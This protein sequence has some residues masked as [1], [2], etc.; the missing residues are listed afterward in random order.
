METREIDPVEDLLAYA[1]PARPLA[2]LRRGDGI[3][4]VGDDVVETIRVSAGSAPLRSDAI[5]DAW[6]TLAQ[7]A[8][9]DDALRLPGSGL[10]AFGALTFD[11]DSAADSVLIVPSL[12]I[13]RHRGRT[14]LT[15]IG[16]AADVHE[17][18]EPQADADTRP[19]GPHWAG[20][21]GPGAQSPQGYQDSVRQALD[22]ISA[23]ELSKVV[24]AR[25]LTGSVPAGS[26]L[27]RLVRALSTGYPDTWAF[28]V[29]GLIGASPETLVTVQQRTVTARVLA[30]TI[31]RGADADADTEASAHL[32]SSTKDLDEHE[33]AVQSVLASLRAHTRVLAASEQPFLLKL[34]NLFHLATDVEGELADGGSSLDL[35]GALHPTAAVAGTPTSA[36][37]AAIRE[38]EP[39]DRG[40]Y[41]GPVG[42]VDAAGNGE[43]AIALR[44]AQFSPEATRIAVTAYAGAGIVSGSDPE[45]ELLETRV[46]F[47]PLVDALA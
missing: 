42:W 30:G 6:R 11:E 1:D 40:R 35:I 44:C 43:W 16:R 23:G 3:V 37:I 45:S 41:A 8:D 14:W 4:A 7:D 2:W 36:A 29:D 22:R 32:A 5:A 24:L 33:Y 31:G 34:P 13:G 12:V 27:R 10:V 25:D 18:A 19:Y 20:T 38:L 46:K 9:V 47:R 17:S 28:A 21:V 26:D 15:R 39:F